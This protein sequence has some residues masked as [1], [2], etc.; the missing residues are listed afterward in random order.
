LFNVT[1]A[2]SAIPNDIRSCAALMGLSGGR[3]WTRYL[4]PAI[5]PGLVTGCIT[6]AGGA[7]NATIVSEYVRS[8]A[9]LT[10]TTGLGAYISRATAA[11]NYSQLAAGVIIMALIVVLINR[12]V[13]KKLQTLANERCRFGA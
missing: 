3:R 5:A 1:S 11:G 4:L 12:F 6:A 8:G 9:L 7:W 10:Q 2:A 13:W